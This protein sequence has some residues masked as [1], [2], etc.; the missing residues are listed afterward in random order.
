MKK[1]LLIF[2]GL[3]LAFDALLVCLVVFAPKDSPQVKAEPPAARP[4]Q[5]RLLENQAD[6]TDS[7]DAAV[8]TSAATL[9]HRTQI[10]ALIHQ[11]LTDFRAAKPGSAEAATILAKLREAIRTATDE[12]ATAEAIVAFLK[13]GEDI[14]TGLPFQV[15]TEGSLAS[16]PSL[17]LALLDLLPGLDPAASLEMARQIMDQRTNA[18]EYALSLRNLAWND[19]EGDLRTELTTRFTAL[20]KSPWVEQPSAGF[21]EAFDIAVE[22]GG[23]PMID[24]LSVLAGNETTVQA[25]LIAL[26]RITLRDPSALV[27]AA[28]Q[29]G[30]MDATPIQRAS[31]LSRLDLTAPDQRALFLRYLAAPNHGEGELE[32]FAKI[33]PNRNYLAGQRLVTTPEVTPS[34]AEVAAADARALAALGEINATGPASEVIAKIRERLK[35]FVK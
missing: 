16:A 5:D 7:G 22:I 3:G 14:A 29:P 1:H 13:T 27:D 18:D 10:T 20:I 12:Q 33:F 28:S 25:A 11:A 9:A 24:Q 17:R 19:L 6:P 4:Q 32:Y 21:L 15:G 34:I 31:L 35:R 26:D 2:L 23:R 30:W 8:P